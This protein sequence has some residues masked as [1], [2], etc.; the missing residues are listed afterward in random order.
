MLSNYVCHF[1]PVPVFV[2]NLYRTIIQREQQ[3]AT[4]LKFGT[5]FKFPIENSSFICLWL[6][7]WITI[8]LSVMDFWI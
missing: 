8:V 3:I 6:G 4:T 7:M 2:L 1:S 5:I